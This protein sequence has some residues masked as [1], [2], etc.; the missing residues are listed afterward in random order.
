MPNGNLILSRKK[1]ESIV[2][3]DD[4]I[5]TVAQIRGGKVRLSIS[6][7]RE[8]SIRREEANK[9]EEPAA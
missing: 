5:I 8:L 7:P 3:D 6:A 1:S 4:I 2:I 9:T